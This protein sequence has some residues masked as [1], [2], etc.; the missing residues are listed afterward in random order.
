MD[1]VDHISDIAGSGHCLV[2]SGVLLVL[3]LFLVGLLELGF[4]LIAVLQH[5]I[6][7]ALLIVEPPEVLILLASALVQVVKVSVVKTHGFIARPGPSAIAA[8][9][10][11]MVL[12][13]LIFVVMTLGQLEPQRGRAEGQIILLLLLE[14]RDLVGLSHSGL[15]H[16]SCQGDN[17]DVF[18]WCQ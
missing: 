9:H 18:D 2:I 8:V 11:G 5:P 7:V 17:L 3:L 10:D 15:E 4:V 14:V 13:E 6:Q 12:L 1:Q 16:D